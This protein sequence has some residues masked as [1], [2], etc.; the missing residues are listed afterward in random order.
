M[1]QRNVIDSVIEKKHFASYKVISRGR[2]SATLEVADKDKGEKAAV[3]VLTKKE[4]ESRRFDFDKIENPYTVK[5]SKH[6]SICRLQTYLIYTETGLCTLADKVNDKSFRKSPEAIEWLFNWIKEIAMG[7]KKLH[8]TG[9]VHLNLQPRC[10]MIDSDNRAKIG[11]F[12]S[13]RHASTV[14]QR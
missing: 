9:F 14:K 3:L 7:M 10:I 4:S 5:A 13:T 12:D 6:E 2:Y 1:D 8:S 11:G